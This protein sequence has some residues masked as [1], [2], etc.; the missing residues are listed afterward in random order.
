MSAQYFVVLADRAHP[1]HECS[2]FVFEW[3]NAAKPFAYLK[4]EESDAEKQV[5]DV[6][7]IEARKD[8]P[9]EYPISLEL[10]ESQVTIIVKTHTPDHFRPERFVF[11]KRNGGPWTCIE[12][13]SDCQVQHEV[14]TECEIRCGTVGL[15]AICEILLPKLRQPQRTNVRQLHAA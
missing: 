4:R 13:W 8:R 14:R 1:E 10:G 12:E 11:S 5:F 9:H 6:L 15:D 2:V 7:D 3:R